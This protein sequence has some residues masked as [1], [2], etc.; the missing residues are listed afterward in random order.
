MGIVHRLWQELPLSLFKKPRLP[1]LCQSPS[2]FQISK[3]H[4][5]LRLNNQSVRTSR[6]PLNNNR[7]LTL[8]GKEFKS[9]HW[10]KNNMT[11]RGACSS[12]IPPADGGGTNTV[13]HRQFG[14]PHRTG[15]SGSLEFF[16]FWGDGNTRLSIE[17][18][19]HWV[20]DFRFHRPPCTPGKCRDI[21]RKQQ[22]ELFWETAEYWP[23]EVRAANINFGK[24]YQ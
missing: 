7:S 18:V 11:W 13:L 8:I 9:F 20:W 1:H 5:S 10:L 15:S 21:V 4:I 23:S 24:S 19:E 2:P 14:V 22:N 17:A 12:A 16:C 3:R 6:L